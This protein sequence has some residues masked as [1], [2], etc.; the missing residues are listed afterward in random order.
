MTTVNAGNESLPQ[1]HVHDEACFFPEGSPQD[2]WIALLLFVGS[3]L[4]LRL[5]YDYTKLNTDEGIVLQGAQRILQGQVPYRDFFAFVTPG[6][7]YWTALLFKIFG[8]SIL[9][10]RVALIVCGGLFSVLSYLL[11]RRVC[12]PWSALLAAYFVTLTCLPYRFLVL[13]NWDSTLLAYLA[14]YSAVWF[15]EK[16]HCTWA[17]ALGSFAALTCLFE[18]SRGAG[19]VLGL[20]MGFLIL[21]WSSRDGAEWTR[22]RLVALLVGFAGPFLLTF[23]YFG[24][25]HSVPQLL[26]DWFWPLHHYS[27]VNKAP[28]GFLALDPA[29]RGDLYAGTFVS[30]FL[31]LLITSPWYLFPF[32]HLWRWVFWRIGLPRSGG[33]VPSRTKAV[34]M[35]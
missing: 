26:A 31:E 25:K 6:S 18:Q 13:H 19:L 7:Y 23:L 22:Q 10:G 24:I 8:S 21:R 29:R 9:V 34:T 14:L 5:F 28:F 30:R 3:C 20:G 32:F 15:I 4:Y 1:M 11:A 2:R 17:F 16:P 12:A 33:E 35:C 27:A